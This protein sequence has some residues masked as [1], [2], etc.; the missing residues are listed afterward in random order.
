[1][2]CVKILEP[3]ER[4]QRHVGIQC[5]ACGANRFWTIYT[6]RRN[7]GIVRLKRCQRCGKAVTTRETLA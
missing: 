3:E 7:T 5:R 2:N 6:R 1:M 4:Q